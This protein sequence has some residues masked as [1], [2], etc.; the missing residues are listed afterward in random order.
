MVY[1]PDGL[2]LQ[3]IVGRLE[4]G[5]LERD[6]GFRRGLDPEEFSVRSCSLLILDN[7]TFDVNCF[8]SFFF[9]DLEDVDEGAC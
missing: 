9:W 3:V 6:G 4:A 1:K 2:T 7:G 8:S 5:A